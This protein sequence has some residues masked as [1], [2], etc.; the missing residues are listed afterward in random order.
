LI[1]LLRAE[2]NRG[3]QGGRGVHD[4]IT[5]MGADCWN[6]RL[7]RKLLE[8]VIPRVQHWQ[9]VEGDYRD[10]RP[11]QATWFIDPPYANE[12]GA[13]YRHASLDYDELAGWVMSRPGQVIVCENVGADWLPF[14]PLGT[15]ARGIKSRY[16]RANTGEAVF[17]V[18]NAKEVAA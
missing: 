9:I 18:N 6:A 2:A 13:R 12:A 17:T 4:V 10:L 5:P 14:E 3:T 16:Q 1:A 7:K 8:A 11:V 15:S